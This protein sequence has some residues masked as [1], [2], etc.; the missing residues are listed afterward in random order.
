[1][2]K[3]DTHIIKT[4]KRLSVLER[5]STYRANTPEMDWMTTEDVMWQ[6]HHILC[7]HSV[8]DA[9]IAKAIPKDD[10][11]FAKACLWITPWKLND[12]HNMIGLPLNWQY[13]DTD[14]KVPENLPSH[15][16]D[17]NTTGGY[18]DECTDWL[19]NNVWNKIKD[20]G[21]DHEA[22][23]ENMNTVLRGASDHFRGLLEDR[24]TRPDGKGTARCWAQ[25]FPKAPPGVTRYKHE[26]KWYFP[27]SMAKDSKV[28]GRQPGINWKS[29]EETL[30]KVK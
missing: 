24:G 9:N 11:P 29:V 3:E 8:T 16:V 22:N 23:A 21:K 26:K 1:M 18:T 10:L 6:A 7:N 17:H 12:A 4:R 20:K 30:R 2:A 5:D 13:R 25:R 14:G 19:K 28:N 15:Q 27:F